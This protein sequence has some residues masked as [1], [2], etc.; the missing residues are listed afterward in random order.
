MLQHPDERPSHTLVYSLGLHPYLGY[1]MEPHAVMLNPNGGLSM[2]HKRL[3]TNTVE[4]YNLVLDETDRRIIQLL[5]EIEQNNIIK[6]TT[7]V[8]CMNLVLRFYEQNQKSR[9]N[10]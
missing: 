7:M 5:E 6:N 10:S 9:K 1:L 4:D 2:T 3:F 8:K